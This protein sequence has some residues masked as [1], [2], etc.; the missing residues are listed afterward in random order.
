MAKQY[1]F[2]V[3]KSKVGEFRAVMD[4][5]AA[6]FWVVAELPNDQLM[7]TDYHN[8]PIINSVLY[9]IGVLGPAGTQEPEEEAK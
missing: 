9:R 4:D 2:T 7:A 5:Q 8:K 1:Q 3:P 6:S